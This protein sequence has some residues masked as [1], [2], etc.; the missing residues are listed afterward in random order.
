MIWLRVL[1]HA[2]Y[3]EVRGPTLSSLTTQYRRKHDP[4]FLSGIAFAI[5]YWIHTK[6]PVI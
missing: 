1:A 6:P 4:L 2:I 5:W 3:A